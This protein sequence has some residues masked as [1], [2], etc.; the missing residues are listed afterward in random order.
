MKQDVRTIHP[1]D[2]RDHGST[3]L[4]GHPLKT[5]MLLDALMKQLDVIVTSHKI[6]LV[7]PR[8]GFILHRTIPPSVTA[9]EGYP[10]S[11]LTQTRRRSCPRSPSAVWCRLQG[12]WA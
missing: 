6:R 9:D 12:S 3:S 4:G 11:T 8:R 5:E 10:S 7:R 1:V 2:M